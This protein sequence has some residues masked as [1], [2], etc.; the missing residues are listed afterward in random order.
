MFAMGPISPSKWKSASASHDD[1]APLGFRSH[2]RRH[3]AHGRHRA[4]A[5]A[6]DGG[7][8]WPCATTTAWL[9]GIAGAGTVAAGLCLGGDRCTGKDAVEGECVQ[10]AHGGLLDCIGNVVTNE[11]IFRS[12]SREGLELG[13]AE[14]CRTQHGQQSSSRSTEWRCRLTDLQKAIMYCC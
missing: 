8:R 5:A 4:A 1:R 2:H 9:H 10:R 7:A 3:Y 11:M 12:R 14:L 13:L 6:A